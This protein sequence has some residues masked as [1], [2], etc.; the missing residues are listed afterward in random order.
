VD[1]ARDAMLMHN[2]GA[3]VHAIRAAIERKWT[4]SYP[5]KTPTPAPPPKK[6]Q[7]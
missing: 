4:P 2:S 5:T 7:P 3:D 1:V 6:K